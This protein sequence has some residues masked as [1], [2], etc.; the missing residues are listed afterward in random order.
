MQL[1]RT[2]AAVFAE[3]GYRAATVR[4]ICQRAGANVAA[5]NYHFGG[6]EQLYLEVLRQTQKEQWT[7]HPLPDSGADVLSPGERLHAFVRSFLSQLLDNR[8]TGVNIRIMAREM[9][10]PTPA[11][12]AV[13]EEFFRPFAESLRAIIRGLMG[14][15][16]SEEQVRLCGISVVGQCLF[17]DHCRSVMPRLFPDMRI[18]PDRLDMLAGHITRY[19]LAGIREAGR[20]RKQAGEFRI[21]SGRKF[22]HTRPVTA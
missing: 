7:M 4:D 10:D 16:A 21:S 1:C 15:A 9:I 17:F 8:L 2:A 12:D 14:P 3:S 11:L 18:G 6:K 19:S 22:K 5:I 13:V 20:H